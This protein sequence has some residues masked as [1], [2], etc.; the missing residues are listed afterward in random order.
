MKIFF[1]PSFKVNLF[2]LGVL[3]FHVTLIFPQCSPNESNTEDNSQNTLSNSKTS[4]PFSTKI[5]D[6]SSKIR[7][8]DTI[9]ILIV[10][11]DTIQFDS[12]AVWSG[13]EKLEL[14]TQR[15]T[16]IFLDTKRLK[17]GTT[18]L[19]SILYT[20]GQETSYLL[21][22]RVLPDTS[23]LNFGYKI[24]KVYPHDRGAFTQGLIYDNGF[25]LEATGL[26]GESSLR[27]VKLD[28]GE[29][30]KSFAVPSDIFGEGIALFDN[31][32]A[33][34][35]WQNRVGFVYEKE[36][37]KL[38]RKFDYYTEG[39]GLTF[40]G[41]NLIMS[42]GSSYLYFLDTVTYT[43][44][45]KIEVVDYNGPVDRLNELEY[46]EGE[47]YAN[48][49]LTDNIVRI[50]PNSGVVTAYIDLK[51]L[52]PENEKRSDTDVLNGIAYDVKQKRIFVTG[53]KWPKLY[54]IS[55]VKK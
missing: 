32:I 10:L 50:N 2:F 36:T 21:S 28:N 15:V 4:I 25:F 24:L 51:G 20:N 13:P 1:I 30:V 9:H 23:P 43:I 6:N 5:A 46:I 17:T 29:V 8:G 27:K 18:A 53:K 45:H 33:Q 12:L 47:I 54:E 49:Y 38:I 31:K 34:L 39:W 52:L 40:D 22:V 11:P 26:T 3:L 35:S 19:K 7:M 14:Y 55:L 41:R 16:D 37:F 44:T 42:D 48:V